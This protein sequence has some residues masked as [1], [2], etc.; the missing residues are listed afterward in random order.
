MWFNA[1]SSVDIPVWITAEL[2]VIPRKDGIEYNAGYR[3]YSK[4]C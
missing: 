4:A 1:D 3:G 2:V